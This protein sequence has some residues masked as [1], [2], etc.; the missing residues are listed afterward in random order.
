MLEKMKAKKIFIG[1]L[2][3]LFLSV[4]IGWTNGAHA[5]KNCWPWTSTVCNGS[6]GF[7]SFEMN[8]KY[9]WE[10]NPKF[11]WE[12]NPKYNFNVN[13]KYNFNANPKYNPFAKPCDLGIGKKC[14]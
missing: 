10:V 2:L 8:P 9:N 13:P 3:T 5:S 6:N 4:A 7:K 11:N 12:A 14:P 1:S